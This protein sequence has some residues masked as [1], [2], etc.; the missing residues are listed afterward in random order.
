MSLEKKPSCVAACCRLH[1][2]AT[3][4]TEDK[5]ISALR[6]S[7]LLLS[8]L[9]VGLAHAQDLSD[10]AA[11]LHLSS[12]ELAKNPK[13][14]L[15]GVITS[16]APSHFLM[17]LQ[18]NGHGIYVLVS[19]DTP[20]KLHVDLGPGDKIVL[21]G[22]ASLGG[23]APYILPKSVRKTG[24]GNL[25]EAILVDAG[26]LNNEQYENLVG[27]VSGRVILA[28]DTIL[29]DGERRTTLQLESGKTRFSAILFGALESQVRS[30]ISSEVEVTG[31]LGTAHNGRRQRTGSSIF[32]AHSSDVRIVTPAQIRWDDLPLRKIDSLLTWGSATKVGDRVRVAGQITYASNGLVYLQDRTG[33]VPVAPALPLRQRLGDFVEV[34]GRLK[35]VSQGSYVLGEALFKPAAV[36]RGK[37]EPLD[38]GID[39]FDGGQLVRVR[40]PIAEILRTPHV[41]TLF[42][43]FSTEGQTAELFRSAGPPA[44]A[45]LEP[46]DMVE[47]TG[48]A[49]YELEPLGTS[50]L[51]LRLRSPA[52]IRLI[53]KRPWRSRFPWGRG[54]AVLGSMVVATFAWIF[55]LRR[56]VSMKTADL[57][58]VNAAKGQFLANMSHEIRTPMNG[59]LGMI[60]IL[61]DTSLSTEQRD[62]GETIQASAVSLL[63]LLNDILDFSKVESGRLQ[64]ERLSFDL[65]STLTRSVDLM[66]PVATEKRLLLSLELPPMPPAAVLGDPLRIRQIVFNF[67]S[68]ALKFTHQGSVTVRFIW[69]PPIA[70]KSEGHSRITVEDTG[71]GMKPEQCARIFQRFEQGD[72]SI[73][74][75]YGGTGLGLAIS[76]SLAEL[77]GGSVGVISKPDQGS[78]FWLELPLTV[79]EPQ[80]VVDVAPALAIQPNA[81]AGSRLLLVEDNRTNQKVATAILKKM[82]CDT[83]VAE[84]GLEALEKFKTN[85][86]FDAILMDCQMPQMDGYET[87]RRLRLAGCCNPII[88][89]TASAMSGE[90]EVCL[91]AGMDDYLTKPF[92]PAELAKVLRTWIDAKVSLPL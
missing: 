27:R 2:G 70:G 47:L 85:S 69:I 60:R 57:E 8:T 75:R 59:I 34:Q 46:G 43:K 68:N 14:A 24:H 55:F 23:F 9:V 10:V 11:V 58:R 31:I 1:L 64:I 63:R 83:I 84:N 91:A 41:E 36:P 3:C 89:L 62:Y 87:A 38:K 37:V 7:A 18:Q 86:N 78:T 19:P 67:L 16:Y 53:S 80:P 5:T 21:Q 72:I 29:P 56:Q 76:R 50:K 48:V 42:L 79:V 51:H 65:A 81:L 17:T 52:D 49:E 88:A 15:S 25:P 71:I 13:V 26:E 54:F 6:V 40:A 90:R 92:R 28:K 45:S 44:T 39:D 74:R 12:G 22:E 30:W 61:L 4:L 32:I 33:G 66:R 82:G 77:M 20:A 73:G 35:D